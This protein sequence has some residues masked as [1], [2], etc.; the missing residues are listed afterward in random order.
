MQIK[1]FFV[2][3]KWEVIFTKYNVIVFDKKLHV[4]LEYYAKAVKSTTFFG[5]FGFSA[6]T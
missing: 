3:E 4:R 6:S 1:L 5:Y 2:S